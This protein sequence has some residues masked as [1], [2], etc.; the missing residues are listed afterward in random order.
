M[1]WA[2]DSSSHVIVSWIQRYI[3]GWLSLT[4]GGP[5]FS[6]LVS[7][8]WQSYSGS[9]KES[10]HQAIERQIL[11]WRCHP[12]II[13]QGKKQTMNEGL[14]NKHWRINIIEVRI[15]SVPSQLMLRH[16]FIW[17]WTT[18]FRSDRRRSQKKTKAIWHIMSCEAH[19]KLV[20]LFPECQRECRSLSLLIVHLGVATVVELFWNHHC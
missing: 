8:S 7:A 11:S 12:I 18:K 13:L 20:S 15:W 3:L 1:T 14:M 2:V 9:N 6:I 5:C 10:I 17:T 19:T 4:L 16:R